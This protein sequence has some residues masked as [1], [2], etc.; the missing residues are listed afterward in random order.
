MCVVHES[1][2]VCFCSILNISDDKFTKQLV[3]KNE[4]MEEVGLCVE[5]P[6]PDFPKYCSN[7]QHDRTESLKCRSMRFQ[8]SYVK[9]T[10]GS[11]TIPKRG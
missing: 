7:E 9:K 11:Q 10:I 4:L 8:Y 5:R 6:F 2:S 3:K 1:L